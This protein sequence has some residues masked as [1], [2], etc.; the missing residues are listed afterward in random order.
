LRAQSRVGIIR[1]QRDLNE[2]VCPL[3]IRRKK[4][5]KFIDEV[6]ECFN[7]GS[8]IQKVAAFQKLGFKLK[9][10]TK[11]KKD[12]NTGKLKGGGNWSFDEYAMVR[13]VS[14]PLAAIIRDSGEEGWSLERFY[15]AVLG[16]IDKHCLDRRELLPPL[17]LKMGELSKMVTTYYDHLINDL[18]LSV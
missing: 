6:I 18:A 9:Y 1:V 4:K 10:K 15:N 17:M 3:D 7:A 8:P 11:P 12:K 5:D 16:V 2:L 14:K 13:Y